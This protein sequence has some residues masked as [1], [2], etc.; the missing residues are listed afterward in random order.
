M[1][2]K[3]LQTLETMSGEA[4]DRWSVEFDDTRLVFGTDSIDGLGV[5]ARELGCGRVLL[6]SDAGV[7]EAGHV[8]RAVAALSR[9]SI[10]AA[11]FDEL[12]AN[13]TTGQVERG[14]RVARDAGVDGLVAVGGGSPMDCAKAI[15]ILL[16]NGGRLEDYRGHNDTGK[17]ALP[18]IGVP[19]TAGTGSD[20]QSFAVI[21]REKSHEK[22][23]C[24]DRRVKFRVVLL[25]PGLTATMPRK[26]A[27][28][29]GLDAMTHAIESYV[30]T[31]R[32]P[33][34]Q[35]L[36][37]EAWSL[38]EG[39]YELVLSPP[40]D[41]TARGRMLL[42]AHLGG[43][44]IEHS[45]LGAAHATANPLTARFELIHGVAVALML[46]HVMRFNEPVAGGLYRELHAAGVEGP[47]T[48]LAERF[49]ELRATAG[50][51]SRLR[52]YGVPR[53][54]LDGLAGE[55]AT[56]WTGESNPR[57]VARRE[58]LDLYEAAF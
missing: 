23:A 49:L 47:A 28:T 8:E 26:I 1:I 46:P 18:S 12:D 56:Q 15:N 21:A 13:P 51:P 25:D 58:F 41:P 3:T 24:G 33:I 11:V 9:E 40:G 22:M 34:S 27:A 39:S 45:M 53:D 37:R 31:R 55:A 19:T 4:T 29:S 6:V 50:L 5:A 32:N 30:C 57:P 44:A 2:E 35:L 7:R 38:L 48:S 10:E 42:G 17:P 36:A 16:A 52:D 14:V 20:A 43:S 54:C